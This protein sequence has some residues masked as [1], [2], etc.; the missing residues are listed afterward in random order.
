MSKVFLMTDKE[1]EVND[2]KRTKNGAT[3]GEG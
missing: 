2:T 1:K 3:Q